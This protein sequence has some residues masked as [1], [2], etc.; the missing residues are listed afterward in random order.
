MIRFLRPFIW[1][2]ALL[3]VTLPLRAQQPEPTTQR[4]DSV[5]ATLDQI[6]QTL[7]RPDLGDSALSDLRVRMDP[8]SR[9]IQTVLDEEQPRLNGIK[10]RIDQ[11][12][13]KPGEKDP[14]EPANVSAERDQQQK[15]YDDVDALVKRAR[16]L[17]VRLD[18]LDSS[19]VD[20]R[21]AL[22]TQ[23]LFSRSSSILDPRLWV[24][25]FR[26][27][28]HDAAALKT[29]VSDWLS[30]LAG[31]LAGWAAVVFIA[32]LA[33][34]F[35]GALLATQVARRVAWR[36]REVHD[37]SRLRR[38]VGA[39]WTALVTVIVPLAAMLALIGLSRAFDLATPRLDPLMDAIFEAV[40]R[41]ALTIGI[42][43]GL[44]APGLVNWRMLDLGDPMVDRLRRLTFSIAL[45]VSAAKVL[46]SITAVIGSSLGVTV[47]T[48]ALGALVVAMT[49][50]GGMY[51]I[52][53]QNTEDD[54]CLAPVVTPTR[55]WYGPM[56]MLAWA[57]VIL[58]VVAV[59]FGYV[60]FAAFV[61]DQLVWITFIGSALYL[62]SHLGRE[63]IVEGLQPQGPLGRIFLNSLGLRRNSLELIAVLLAGLFSGAMILI[64]TMLV[65]APWGIESND[66]LSSVRAAIFGFKVGDVSIS[67]ASVVF[68]ILLFAV[69]FAATRGLQRWLQVHFLPKTQLD[70][71][72][73]DSIRVSIGYTGIMVALAV[74]LGYLGLNFERVA[75]VAGALSVGIGLGLQSIV[76]NFVS[77]LIL[78]W[79]R[80][81]RVGDWVVI[82]ADQGHVRRINVRST[83]IETFDRATLIVPNSNIVTGVVKNWVRDDKAGRIKVPVTVNTGVDPV[84]VRDVLIDVARA[85]ELVLKLP[86]PTVLFTSMAANGINFELVCFVSDIEKSARISSDLNFAIFSSFRAEGFEL[87]STSSLPPVA[88]VTGFEHLGAYLDRSAA[89]LRSASPE[90]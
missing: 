76:N 48:R 62:L 84:K 26:D 79:E 28:P 56:R 23:A 73:Q 22:F 20:R 9:V 78:L 40:T 31:K 60:A 82:G 75:L 35:V 57:A 7:A 51:G 38:S 67:L 18:Q 45:I 1:L 55:D 69:G 41:I 68:S 3:A 10:V 36:D 54:Q 16:L 37:P 29:I 86:A 52:A 64:A 70:T 66:M 89:N 5:R 39:V 47:L 71:G 13:A 63:A 42:A 4:L 58:I 83:E 72:L 30:S 15:Q 43:Q 77:G 2:F 87:M 88:T 6:E 61:V 46:E 27:L 44:L 12:G 17:S 34:I 74:A 65:L 33:A 21:R 14:A 53:G 25:V 49:L 85:H 50:S 81:I 24:S 32:G 11:L 8:L 19:V 80:A 90:K 59:V